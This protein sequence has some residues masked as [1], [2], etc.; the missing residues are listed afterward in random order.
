MLW[1]SVVVNRMFTSGGVDVHACLSVDHCYVNVFIH[2]LNFGGW[3]QPR[4]Y[5][6]SEIFPI[7]SK[8]CAL[9]P[10]C[11]HSSPQDRAGTNSPLNFEV[12]GGWEVGYPIFVSRVEP[13]SIPEMA[14][15]R[16]GD[17]VGVSFQ[18]LDWE[19][20]CMYSC[21]AIQ[22]HVWQSWVEILCDS[23]VVHHAKSTML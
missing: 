15:I 8:A 1:L 9:C 17:Q 22:V 14:G 10:L 12:V 2:V 16:V 6:N 7:Y 20:G 11:F 21:I 13:S 18:C 4:N 19:W 5:F 23:V 3:S